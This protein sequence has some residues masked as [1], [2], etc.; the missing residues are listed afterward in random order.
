MDGDLYLTIL[1]KEL[2]QSLEFYDLDPSN[3]IFQQDNNLKHI[4]KKIQEWLKNQDF[5]VLRWPA[6]SADLNPIEHIWFYLKRKLAKYEVPPK[7][8]LEL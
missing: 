4:Y 1:K 7:G 2:Q 8:I 3:I 5:M 6:Q